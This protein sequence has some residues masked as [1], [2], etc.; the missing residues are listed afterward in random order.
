MQVLKAVYRT[1]WCRSLA[2]IV[3]D[4]RSSSCGASLHGG[5]GRRSLYRCVLFATYLC[6]GGGVVGRAY[7]ERARALL[8]QLIACAVVDRATFARRRR[9]WRQS[10][11]QRRRRRYRRTRRRRERR[12]QRRAH[13]DSDSDADRSN[14]GDSVRAR[15]PR[16]GC[17]VAMLRSRSRSRF[18]AILRPRV[19]SDS[20]WKAA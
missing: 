11:K 17:C 6:V 18:G 3:G 19:D 7:C 9:R 8:H 20:V 2:E 14:D 12:R 10:Q 13:P 16:Q 4:V 1:C 15:C 5:A